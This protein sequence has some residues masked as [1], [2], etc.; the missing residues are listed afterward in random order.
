M[1]TL[2]IQEPNGIIMGGLHL[3]DLTSLIVKRLKEVIEAC[4]IETS[5]FSNECL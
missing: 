5:I 3:V 4:K 2:T 1:D